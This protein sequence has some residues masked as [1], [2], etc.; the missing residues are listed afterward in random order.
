MLVVKAKKKENGVAGGLL[1]W[2]FAK[3]QNQSQ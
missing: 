1:G 2:L 3:G